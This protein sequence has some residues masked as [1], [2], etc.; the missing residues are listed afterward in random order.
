METSV[1]FGTEAS[2]AGA[3]TGGVFRITGFTLTVETL[4]TIEGTWRVRP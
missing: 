4:L 3:L 2:G 1:A